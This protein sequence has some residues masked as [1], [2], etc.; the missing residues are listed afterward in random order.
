MYIYLLSL[1]LTENYF[2]VHGFLKSIITIISRK[3]YPKN[4]LKKS[5]W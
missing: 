1:Q 2:P 4:I 5:S 3:I